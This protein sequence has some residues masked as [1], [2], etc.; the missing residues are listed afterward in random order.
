M[1]EI[2]VFCKSIP[3]H[4]TSEGLINVFPDATKMKIWIE[5][6]LK[7]LCHGWNRCFAFINDMRTILAKKILKL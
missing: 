6:K 1:K 5:M 7:A 3:D 4:A 2:R